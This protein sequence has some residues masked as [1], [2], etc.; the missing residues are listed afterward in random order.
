MEREGEVVDELMKLREKIARENEWVRKFAAKEWSEENLRKMR[1]LLIFGI[2][3]FPEAGLV[4]GVYRNGSER[5]IRR[6]VNEVRRKIIADLEALG[7]VETKDFVVVL[8]NTKRDG[9]GVF[10]ISGGFETERMRESLEQIERIINEGARY[11]EEKMKE[12]EEKKN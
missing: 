9:N 10:Y 3:A 6:V 1:K 4:V 7:L 12:L 8:L 5:E 11:W 2:D